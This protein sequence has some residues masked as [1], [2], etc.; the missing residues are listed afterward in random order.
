MNFLAHLYLAGNDEGLIVGNF[1]ADAVKGKA[2]NNYNENI[3]RGILMHRF[4]DSY[5]DSHPVVEQSKKRLRPVHGKFS[6]VVIDMFYD[7]LLAAEWTVYHNLALPV[8]SEHTYNVLK[9]HRAL[10]PQKS[11]YI[12]EHMS[13]RNWL[14]GYATLEGL[15]RA[16]EGMWKRAA[17]ASKMNLAVH[18][19]E[20]D[21]PLYLEEFNRFFPDLV[22][23]A[24]DFIGNESGF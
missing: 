16:L 4:I 6:P 19:L 8:F 12:L 3:A 22:K 5:T 20:K 11:N 13:A 9:R 24:N 10:L 18:D 15:Q 1:I 14:T 21:Y 7:H 2:W 17:F 23:A